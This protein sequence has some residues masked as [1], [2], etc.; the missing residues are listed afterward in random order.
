[1]G[2]LLPGEDPHIR[3]QVISD[4]TS[5]GT[6]VVTDAGEIISGIVEL[7]YNVKAG[8]ARG[9]LTLVVEDVHRFETS[10]QGAN[11]VTQ[12]VDPWQTP[13]GIPDKQWY[14]D[15][16][17]PYDP[18]LHQ[19]DDPQAYWGNW[20]QR[21]NSWFSARLPKFQS[22]HLMKIYILTDSAN[23]GYE[24]WGECA[25]GFNTNKFNLWTVAEFTALIENH[26]GIPKGQLW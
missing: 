21:F 10:A 20:H 6:Q 22:A 18:A 16:G 11:V 24:L 7:T 3:L 25:C 4:G 19:F 9:T 23:D 5:V 15:R 13:A 26:Y 14:P 12:I 8:E 17:V 2:V 1:M